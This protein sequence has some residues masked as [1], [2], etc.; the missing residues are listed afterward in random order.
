M[1]IF[2]FRAL[3]LNE[4]ADFI[5]EFIFNAMGRDWVVKRILIDVDDDDEVMV[6]LH[7]DADIDQVRELME[8]FMVAPDLMAQTLLA[9][10]MSENKL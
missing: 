9:C 10:P 5:K 1:N 6:E 3:L 4:A 2:S 8:T 7:T